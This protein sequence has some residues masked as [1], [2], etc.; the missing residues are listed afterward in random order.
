MPQ[1]IDK[2]LAYLDA[3]KWFMVGLVSVL[4]FAFTVFTAIIWKIVNRY[5]KQTV[6]KISEIKKTFDIL[7]D[8]I[9]KIDTSDRKYEN[10][11]TIIKK[12]VEF[13]KEICEKNHEWNGRERRQ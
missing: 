9:D 2:V 1:N 6:E 10:A 13:R 8:K 11:L 3:L 4:S 5:D 12:D 7:F